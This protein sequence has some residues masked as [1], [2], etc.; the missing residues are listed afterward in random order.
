MGYVAVVY[1]EW[2]EGRGGYNVGIL[3]AS[4]TLWKTRL[5]LNTP[6]LSMKIMQTVGM[7]P[8]SISRTAVT[9]RIQG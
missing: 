3:L 2:S 9:G 1:R 6:E 5:K 7:Y 4:E 8:V